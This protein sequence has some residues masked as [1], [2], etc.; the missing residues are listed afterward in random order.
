M[1][2]NLVSNPLIEQ[3]GAIHS[4]DRNNEDTFH[5]QLQNYCNNEQGTSKLLYQTTRAKLF[6]HLETFH[7]V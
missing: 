2:R 1:Q 4:H 3:S 6:H 5:Q 7:R